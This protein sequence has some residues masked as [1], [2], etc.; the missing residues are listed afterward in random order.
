[1]DIRDLIFGPIFLAIIYFIAYRIRNKYYEHS[2]IRKYFIPGL[3]VK[4]LGAICAGLVYEFYYGGGDTF[5]FF[6][7]TQI[8]WDAMVDSPI[9]G[10]Q[11]LT[12]EAGEF[13][14]RTYPYASQMYFYFDSLSYFV[15]KIATVVSFLCFDSYIAIAM[16][17]ACV[18]FSGAWALYRTLLRIYPEV[19]RNLAIAILFIPSVFFW[20]SGLFKDTITFAALSWLTYAC[21]H[22]FIRRDRLISS[23]IIM[24]IC[25]YL[26]VNIKVYIIMCFVTGLVIWLFLTYRKRLDNQFLKILFTPVLIVIAG[27][28]SY[29]AIQ[30]VGD[31]F[32]KYSFEKIIETAADVQWWHTV[33]TEKEGGSVYSLGEYDP[34]LIGILKKIPL[35]LNVTLFRPY[36]FEAK[37]I[38]MLFSA[39]ESLVLLLFTIYIVIK[40]RIFKIF[41]ITAAHPEIFFCMIFALIFA[42]AVGFTSYNFGALVRYKIPCLPFYVAG[43]MLINHH[44]NRFR[45]L[46]EFEETL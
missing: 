6:Q 9:T 23:V 17:F 36:I 20:G 39:I 43:L 15:V 30:Q 38:V 31:E 34:T 42:F 13:N 3:S 16:I 35:A 5:A 44:L 8:I 18:S 4:L 46:A 11:L 22:F 12:A 41:T 1:M 45:K 40:A 26:I 21:Y 19:H 28:F 25:V 33:V 14:P 32:E 24:G 7:G 27:G 10:F 2:A 29:L 37:N